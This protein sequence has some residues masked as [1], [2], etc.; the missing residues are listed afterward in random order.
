MLKSTAVDRPW[1]TSV[2]TIGN[3][4]STAANAALTV[5]GQHFGEMY[6]MHGQLGCG[7]F[8]LGWDRLDNGIP[9]WLDNIQA[10]DPS[11][12]AVFS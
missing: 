2:V 3:A 11:F 5:T 7:I 8:G 1:A 9:M 4:S 12:E 10:Q 6:L